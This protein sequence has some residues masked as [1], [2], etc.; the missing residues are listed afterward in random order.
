MFETFWS[1]NHADEEDLGID[2]DFP[3]EV[4][5]AVVL[6]TQE[7]IRAYAAA[8]EEV[9]RH[10]CL[11]GSKKVTKVSIVVFLCVPVVGWL[12]RLRRIGGP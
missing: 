1:G 10:F 11:A 12:T 3:V 8:D 4:R 5:E 7:L 2:Y 6:Y 9:R